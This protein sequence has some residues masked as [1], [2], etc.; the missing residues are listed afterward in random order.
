MTSQTLEHAMKWLREG[1]LQ[2]IVEEGNH[3][4]P[5]AFD[6]LSLMFDRVFG[7]REGELVLQIL[8]DVTLFRTPVDHRLGEGE[9]YLRFAQ[10]RAGQNQLA[11]TIVAYLT[12]AKTLKEAPH[13]RSDLS[14]GAPG[15]P[16]R[17]GY[18]RGPSGQWLAAEP[19]GDASGPGGDRASGW[20]TAVR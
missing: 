5:D 12:H 15:E 8:L 1:A 16:G 6:R 11:A 10:L 3:E 7:S 4:S 13:E 9:A 20:D 14:A 18:T 2:P 17:A 19:T